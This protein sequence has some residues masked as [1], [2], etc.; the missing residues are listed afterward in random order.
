MTDWLIYGLHVTHT[1]NKKKKNNHRSLSSG[2]SENS[3]SRRTSLRFTRQRQRLA[4][5]VYTA[6]YSGRRTLIASSPRIV[7]S[8]YYILHITLVSLS[9][10]S[11]KYVRVSFFFLPRSCVL[12][13]LLR[14]F[15]V[16]TCRMVYL[17]VHTYKSRCSTTC[18]AITVISVA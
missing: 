16:M 11:K 6:G 1:S 8:L 2:I 15:K 13:L 5:V 14:I 18:T 3:Y 7:V 17:Q 4:C 12:R 9:R 10:S